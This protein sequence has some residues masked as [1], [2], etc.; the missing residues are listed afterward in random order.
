MQHNLKSCSE[1]CERK[2]S[3]I[4][5]QQRQESEGKALEMDVS[6]DR[7]RGPTLTRPTDTLDINQWTVN[8][9]FSRVR[10]CACSGNAVQSESNHG[11]ELDYGARSQIKKKIP[12]SLAYL[13]WCPG[14]Y[15]GVVGF[16]PTSR[17][18]FNRQNPGVP[19][20][21]SFPFVSGTE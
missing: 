11:R 16:N 19:T 5:R 1:P 15:R 9:L 20:F 3:R 6:E 14:G 13:L 7:S 18:L 21:F 2:E 8:G 10:K 4:Q 17:S 12:H